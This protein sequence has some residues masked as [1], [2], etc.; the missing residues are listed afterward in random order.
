MPKSNRF[1]R[2]ENAWVGQKILPKQIKRGVLIQIRDDYE[3]VDGMGVVTAL[4]YRCP[5]G[6]KGV[7]D[8][9]VKE[10]PRWTHD[11][12]AHLVDFSS[13]SGPSVLPSIYSECGAH[14][15]INKGDIIWVSEG[16][17]VGAINP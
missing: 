12:P 6:C 1:H 7:I 11:S 5:C 14:Y 17:A 13:P 9:P 2:I 10:R 15:F 4:K 16:V 3:K 8:M